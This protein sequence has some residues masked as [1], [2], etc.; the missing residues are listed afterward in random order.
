MPTYKYYISSAHF[1]NIWFLYQILHF[2]RKVPLFP[3]SEASATI[4]PLSS[5]S[6]VSLSSLSLSNSVI[7]SIS[8]TNYLFVQLG[9]LDLQIWEVEQKRN[10]EE[11]ARNVFW[12]SLFRQSLLCTGW[13]KK[14]RKGNV[15]NKFV[16]S[17][18][19][20]QERYCLAVSSIVF[21]YE[22]CVN[23]RILLSRDLKSITNREVYW[24]MIS[25]KNSINIDIIGTR[26]TPI[27]V[28]MLHISGNMNPHPTK[29]TLWSNAMFEVT[30]T[31]TGKQRVLGTT[32]VPFE[33]GNDIDWVTMV[34]FELWQYEVD[35][36]VVTTFTT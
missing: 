4:F 6:S 16:G 31:L 35:S 18:W 30:A 7:V 23:Q 22:S 2:G 19:L 5:G 26:V 21:T 14:V 8:A 27:Y 10:G 15:N 29:V 3:T 24:F 17:W 20:T 25:S 34:D 32:E 11:R 13:M 36:I 12:K 28:S 1:I 9:F 33:Y